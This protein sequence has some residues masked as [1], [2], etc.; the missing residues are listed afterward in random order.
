VV[1]NTS[2]SYNEDPNNPQCIS[3][4]N[5][6]AFRF[7]FGGFNC[8]DLDKTFN[9]VLNIT[10]ESASGG[11]E[12]LIRYL[13]FRVLSPLDIISISP[14]ITAS[15][16]VPVNDAKSLLLTIKNQGTQP[17][18]FNMTASTTTGLF[19]LINTPTNQYNTNTI[20]DETFTLQPKNSL[21]YRLKVVPTSAGN[22]TVQITFNSLGACAN[23]TDYLAFQ[24]TGFVADT[25]FFNVY[26]IPAWDWLTAL[27]LIIVPLIVLY[28][29]FIK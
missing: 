29:K 12:S 15:L 7:N 2:L 17:I 14:E 27:V 24:V 22:K 6:G 18:D 16:P 28:K 1:T 21:I 10:Y 25:S 4:G 13:N 3:P 23:V 9:P 20:S 5:S 26:E 8:D 11:V 19:M